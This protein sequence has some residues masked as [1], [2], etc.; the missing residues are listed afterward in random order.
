MGI[1]FLIFFSFILPNWENRQIMLLG[2]Q[3]MNDFSTLNRGVC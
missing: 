2:L 1:L 3:N